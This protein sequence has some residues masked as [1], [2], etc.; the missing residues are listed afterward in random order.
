MARS[1]W[2][3]TGNQHTKRFLPFTEALAVAR[4]FN[5]PNRFEWKAWCKEGMRP[6]E[7]ALA[8]GEHPDRTYK[9]GGWQGWGHC[10]GTGNVAGGQPEGHFLPFGQALAVAQ[11][12]NLAHEGVEG[13]VHGGDAPPDAPSNPHRTYTDAGWQ[14]WGLWLGS[15]IQSSKTKKFLPFGEARRVARRL[16]LVSSTEWRAWCRC[17]ARPVNVPAAPD[18]VYEH[19][20][21]A[22][23]AHWLRRPRPGAATTTATA[24]ARPA[25]TSA[26]RRAVRGRRRARAPGANVNGSGAEPTSSPRL[27]RPPRPWKAAAVVRSTPVRATPGARY[28]TV[29]PYA[30]RNHGEG[31]LL[32]LV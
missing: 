29:L 18:Q 32:C 13:M 15:G 5:L 9:G 24:A 4:S 17:G 1:H 19:D 22:G 12:L 14:G 30:H 6:P 20:G 16:R 26:Q 23:Y 10:L 21:W 25:N 11:S 8:P 27:P 7:R 2:L 3:G 28:R 31:V